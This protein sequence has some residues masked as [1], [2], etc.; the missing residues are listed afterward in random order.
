MESQLVRFDYE[1]F[2]KVQGVFFRKYTDKKAKELGVRGWVMNTDRNTVVGTVEG[3]RNAA[4][5]MKNWLR[6]QGSPKS[7]IERC[8]ISNE[9]PISTYSFHSFTLRR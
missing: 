9:A 4:E 5:L 1:V 2:G 3:P 6:T 8:V 7:R